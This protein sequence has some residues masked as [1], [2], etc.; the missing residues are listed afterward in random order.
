MFPL[1][2][3]SHDVRVGGDPWYRCWLLFPYESSSRARVRR[4]EKVPFCGEICKIPVDVDWVAVYIAK[5]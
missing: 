4:G 3:I 1:T 2:E 5:I